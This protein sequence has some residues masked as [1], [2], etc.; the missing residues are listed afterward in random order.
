MQDG[1][2]RQQWTHTANIMALIANCNRD[3]KRQRRPFHLA[4]FLPPDLRR[5]VRRSSGG[6]PL[7]TRN[8]HMFKP[9]F[10]K[11]A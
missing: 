8:L 10:T 4:D 11:G 3:P 5:E 9:L 1:R 6:I 2:R 7:T